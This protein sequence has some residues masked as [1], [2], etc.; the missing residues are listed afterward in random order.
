MKNAFFETV[1]APVEQL[2]EFAGS[3]C[4]RR[5]I[6]NL[7]IGRSLSREESAEVVADWLD[8]IYARGGFNGTVLFARGG[9]IYFERHYGFT[10]VDAATPLSDRSSFSLASVSKQFTAMGILILTYR[11]K[12]TLHDRITRHIPELADYRDITLRQMLHHTSGLPDYMDL[13][14]QYWDADHLFTNADLIALLQRYRPPLD[15]P[16]GEQYEYSN[17]GYALLGDVIAR[18]SGKSYAEF[19][20][21]EIFTSLGMN[22][23][24]AFNLASKTCPL[25]CR[26]FGFRKRYVCFGKKVR[27]DLN[28]LDGVF[29]DGG[30]YASAEDLA[31]WDLGLRDSA[32]IP[33]GIYQQAYVSGV[34]NNGEP[35]GYGFGWGV[36]TPNVVEHWGEWEGFTSYIRRDLQDQSLLVLLSNQGPSACVDPI[37]EELAA[38]IDNTQV[39]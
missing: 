36:E 17:T 8:T 26:V 4:C 27:A 23:S 2:V 38:L 1:L 5:K 18:V 19:M 7:T 21:S 34:L 10:D 15:F 13:A 22:D 29:G 9:R 12:L 25:H 31:R 3:E 35:T 32:L 24:A 37:G 39:A 28:Y 30:I 20:A 14:G 6:P 16:P 33:S 11:G